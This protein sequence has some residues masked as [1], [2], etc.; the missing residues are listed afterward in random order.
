MQGHGA[1][2]EASEIANNVQVA[3][4]LLP[5]PE[6][7]LIAL[8]EAA[9]ILGAIG[10]GRKRVLLMWQA[11]E[12]SK[13]F[14]F[15]DTRTLAVAREALEPAAQQAQQHPLGGDG[16]LSNEWTASRRPLAQET[17]I[18]A[19]WGAVRAGC[20]EAT[21]GLAIYAKRHAD[22]WDAAAA[23]L[24]DHT[25]QLSN[26]RMESLMENLIAAASQMQANERSR[27]GKGPPPLLR[28]PT[29]RAP[30]AP[31]APIWIHENPSPGNASP[32]TIQ[33]PSSLQSLFLYDPFSARRQKAR[34]ELSKKGGICGDGDSSNMYWVCGESGVLD[35]EVANPSSVSI[36][37]EKMVLEAMF[38]PET[39]GDATPA[40]AATATGATGDVAANN[41]LP[42]PATKS[43]WKG[44]PVS[45]NIPAHTKP[46]K[47]QL[48]GVP[49]APGTLILKGCRLT[50]F[51]G[52]SWSQPWSPEPLDLTK[53]LAATSTKKLM[54]S[55][56]LATSHSN[57][58]DARSEVQPQ[59]TPAG[60]AT[61]STNGSSST[62]GGYGVAIN[63]RMAPP[64]PS[65]VVTVLP[66]LPKLELVLQASTSGSDNNNGSATDASISKQ[67]Q[68][69]GGKVGRGATTTTS[70]QAI[71]ASSLNIL[72]GQTISASLVLTNTGAVL[73]DTLRV[74]LGANTVISGGT[75]LVTT[76]KKVDFSVDLSPLNSSPVLDPG[77]S[78]SLPVNLFA[79]GSRGSAQIEEIIT[80]NISVEYSSLH[81][82]SQSYAA[83]VTEGSTAR[84]I[85]GRRAVLDV[86][87]VV[88][89]SLHITHIDFAEIFCQKSN[90]G[91]ASPS[92]GLAGGGGAG[93]E[94]NSFT[95]D[96]TTSTAGDLYEGKVLMMAE[97][98]NRGR[99]PLEA[100]LGPPSST[101]T[102]AAAVVNREG[103]K[104]Q[105]T[106]DS[107]K[108][109]IYPGQRGTI[110][111]L[112]DLGAGIPRT[113]DAY[114]DEEESTNVTG[115]IHSSSSLAA[116]VFNSQQQQ[117][118]Q[119]RRNDH[120]QQYFTNIRYPPGNHNRNRPLRF[121]DQER[122]LCAATL[123]QRVVL[124]YALPQNAEGTAEGGGVVGS[125][126]NSSS[127]TIGG[128]TSTMIT[129]SNTAPGG[130]TIATIT[131]STTTTS[132]STSHSVS[133]VP[134]SIPLIH[135][136]I[137]NGLT[138]STLSMLRPHAV[139]IRISAVPL[140][141]LGTAV[142]GG[143]D[144][145]GNLSTVGIQMHLPGL[146]SSTAA[147][148]AAATGGSPNYICPALSVSIGQ[149]L[150]IIAEVESYV[151]EPTSVF[152]SLQC[153]PL[154]L[155]SG[156]ASSGAT[157][158]LSLGDGGGG[159]TTSSSLLH[160]ATD[161]NAPGSNV[162][163]GGYLMQSP[164]PGGAGLSITLG[165]GAVGAVG[166]GV[167]PMGSSSQTNASTTS[168]AW[169]GMHSQLHLDI[170]A[171]GKVRHV[172]GV[173]FVLPG[174]YRIGAMPVTVT[175]LR[176]TGNSNNTSATTIG[177]DQQQ[178]GD[179][180]MGVS[181]VLGKNTL[182]VM[183][184]VFVA[185]GEGGTE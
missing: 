50:A 68:L 110:S 159:G 115:R 26:H 4:E 49:L 170:P 63:A 93:R 70:A 69:I 155:P 99:W 42:R 53:Q 31:L 51:G 109:V 20:L 160:N 86:D 178:Q 142:K 75:V 71:G 121:E 83:A 66:P 96:S 18:P 1:R 176:D 120:N 151:D 107:N 6:D 23:L 153:G 138:P 41:F 183:Q 59:T 64:S 141:P 111:Y 145:S 81:A 45:L 38:I 134:G 184:P 152:F 77:K 169:T 62:N 166:G 82:T 21:L 46:V 165:S 52:V 48:E 173:A 2:T 174:M 129:S 13:Y 137:Y 117:Q 171:K 144:G 47:I 35:I 132:N 162:V 131:H 95:D 98:V 127:S 104:N 157:A 24:R 161:A 79:P 32:S 125:T 90:T 102:S 3:A 28:G 30:P 119:Q 72:Q 40:A 182:V 9:A 133:N 22:V 113:E 27:P 122:Q 92:L 177:A 150:K 76:G 15:P 33:S 11:V 100:W 108:V 88:I 112:L 101:S 136:E 87:V 19:C 55:G 126:I 73:I 148:P 8:T 128:T 103:R 158:G 124:H 181:S 29:P 56:G 36:Q 34:G 85:P 74:E 54:L 167:M 164:R 106:V 118:Q 67:Q 89:P 10:A 116:S 146:T 17:T 58:A 94:R 163:S 105:G 65:P 135:G 185:I 172:A 130:G 80:E 123:A 5:L 16:A 14:G 114:D 60:A 25:N 97:A 91:S 143:S 139:S 156:G 84:L 154:G 44:K 37:I 168:A 140:P 12:L 149:P 43:I 180:S 175:Y 147:A 61:G 7:R 179:D 57:G 39:T 78:I